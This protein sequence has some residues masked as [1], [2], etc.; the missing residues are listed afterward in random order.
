M[1]LK[2]EADTDKVIQ[3]IKDNVSRV[4]LPEDAIDPNVSEISTESQR[5][6]SVF[7][8]NTDPATSRDI[9]MSRAKSIKE[10]FE[11][12]YNIDTVVIDGGESSELEVIIHG[13]KLQAMNV[14]PA[15]IADIIK[16]YNQ[17]FPIG[18]FT[19]ATKEYDLRIEGDVESYESLLKIPVSLSSGASVTLGEFATIQRKWTN[20][21]L[22]RMNRAGLTNVPFVQLTFNKQ[23]RKSVFDTAAQVRTLLAEKVI[24]F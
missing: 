3:Q 12:K 11:G 10:L 6:F 20:T 13:G 5:L 9:L 8:S 4:D 16:Q 17:S 14:T 18:K 22:E 15:Q 19:L 21:S 24:E 7:L 2:A 1:T 23:P